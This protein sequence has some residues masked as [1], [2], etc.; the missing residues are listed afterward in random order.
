MR[1]VENPRNP[2]MPMTPKSEAKNRSIDAAL[3]RTLSIEEQ[4]KEIEKNQ[5]TLEYQIER[6]RSQFL[7]SRKG[8]VKLK[9]EA[10][11]PKR[12]T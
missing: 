10:G 1:S 8:Y 6:L 5:L 12:K 2:E 9:T 11:T 7:K 4:I 3:K